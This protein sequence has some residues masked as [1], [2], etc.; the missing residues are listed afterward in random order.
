MI[1]LN[2]GIQN[3]NPSS[4]TGFMNNN[5]NAPA[6]D[7]SK[8]PAQMTI[9]KNQIESQNAEKVYNP[10]GDFAIDVKQ[11]NMYEVDP[12]VLLQTGNALGRG[13]AGMM[14]RMQDR[15][16]S[17][18]M[19]D[20]LSA[21]N[22]YSATTDRDRGDYTKSGSARGEFRFDEQG[23][24]STGRFAQYGGTSNEDYSNDQGGYFDGD[25][26]Y[27]TEDQIK[28]FLEA[29]GEIEYL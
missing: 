23:A 7:M 1:S 27:M 14:N 9:D 28:Q 20:D 17:R 26:A 25:E 15:K 22:L 3:L 13:Y 29:G 19:Y 16:N 5:N 10:S 4:L 18:K 11:K 21:D 24:N 6:R 2:P 12:E 8:D